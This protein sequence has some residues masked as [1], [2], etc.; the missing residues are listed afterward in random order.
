M[1]S[2]PD[3]AED[4]RKHNLD[5]DGKWKKAKMLN[6]INIL[7]M[8][9]AITFLFMIFWIST[10]AYSQQKY[11]DTINQCKM[12]R[13]IL[14]DTLAIKFL[15]IREEKQIYLINKTK[16]DVDCNFLHLKN[17]EATIIDDEP[18]SCNN[19]YDFHIWKPNNKDKSVSVSV[20]KNS[21]TF[22]GGF[23]LKKG[24]L[25]FKRNGYGVM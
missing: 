22:Y 18:L 13:I 5:Y 4:K 16:L 25:I 3:K 17:A 6:I 21:L 10:S 11:R 15:K 2:V 7:N 24:K 19:C 9:R 23:T 8:K 20:E 14:D 1:S 12:L